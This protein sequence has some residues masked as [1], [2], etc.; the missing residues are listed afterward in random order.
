MNATTR[1]VWVPFGFCL[2]LSVVCVVTHVATAGSAAW[3][4]AFLCFLPMAFLFSAVSNYKTC[5]RV[6][7]LEVRLGPGEGK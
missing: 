7:A 6:K 5:Q 4:H 3:V 2:A 1:D